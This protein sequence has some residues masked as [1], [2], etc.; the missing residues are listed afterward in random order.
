MCA[1]RGVHTCLPV[2]SSLWASEVRL[3]V[4]S[5]HLRTC[6][7]EHI[8]NDDL[9]A[10]R[11][12]VTARTRAFGAGRRNLVSATPPRPRRKAGSEDATRQLQQGLLDSK[13][14][15]HRHCGVLRREE[16]VDAAVCIL[17]VTHVA[18]WHVLARCPVGPAARVRVLE[19]SK[20][21]HR[22]SGTALHVWIG[23]IEALA[24]HPA[25]RP[26]I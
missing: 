22:Y 5:R 14:R 8:I 10:D 25:S 24:M 19:S 18:R 3:K 11:L 4:D 15:P 9:A 6:H 16:S 7:T 21:P 26:S 23:R 13:R 1:Q 17:H 2:P 20:A 12:T